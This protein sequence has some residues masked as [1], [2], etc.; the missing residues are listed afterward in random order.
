MVAFVSVI[1]QSR[2][3]FS[4]TVTTSVLLCRFAFI[5]KLESFV[6]W[7][8]RSDCCESNLVFCVCRHTAVDVELKPK[9]AE[10]PPPPPPSPPITTYNS[11]APFPDQQQPVIVKS[12]PSL[13]NLSEN[14]L[15]EKV[16]KMRDVKGGGVLP[17]RVFLQS[18]S[19]VAEAGGGTNNGRPIY[20]NCPFSPYGSPTGSPRSN[21]KRQPLKESRRV[22]IEKTGMYI[23][24]NQYKLMD[25]IG[26]VWSNLFF[27]EKFTSS[28]RV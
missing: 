27:Y 5:I 8:I 14:R 20:P 26:Q 7:E 13:R 4:S 2:Y 12:V 16:A 18:K 9:E 21:R 1:T 23:Q 15:P 11:H 10:K 25:A 24:L 6:S 3:L 28:L 19:V 17:S 22:S